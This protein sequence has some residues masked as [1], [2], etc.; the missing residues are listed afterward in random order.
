MQVLQITLRNFLLNDKLQP[1]GTHRPHIAIDGLYL[2]PV[3]SACW[4]LQ[5]GKEDGQQAGSCVFCPDFSEA[6]I[7]RLM[8]S[9]LLRYTQTNGSSSTSIV[10]PPH[11]ETGSTL[12]VISRSRMIPSVLSGCLLDRSCATGRFTILRLFSSKSAA[13]FRA[14]AI[15]LIRLLIIYRKLPE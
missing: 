8:P 10:A 15:R 2:I 9:E 5:A 1:K 3:S 6:N 12:N 11:S 13:T 14:T 4:L 7:R